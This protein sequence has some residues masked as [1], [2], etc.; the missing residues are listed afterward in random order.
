MRLSHRLPLHLE[1]EEITPAVLDIMGLNRRLPRQ[2][3]RLEIGIPALR[4]CKRTEG[5]RST[6]GPAR[7]HGPAQRHGVAV[8]DF[9]TNKMNTK[10]EAFNQGTACKHYEDI[11]ARR[12]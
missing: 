8:L 11:A 2:R 10:I 6:R 1:F 12:K 9:V 3:A 4:K 5:C 7:F